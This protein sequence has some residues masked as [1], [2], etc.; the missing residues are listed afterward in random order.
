MM[1]LLGKGG[2]FTGRYPQWG[3]NVSVLGVEGERVSVCC[4][5]V[6]KLN[7]RLNTYKIHYHECTI[8]KR[9]LSLTIN[10]FAQGNPIC[11]NT[12]FA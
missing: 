5:I 8:S 9:L 3:F 6:Q 2:S 7:K 10:S 1:L 4:H 11:K 12:S